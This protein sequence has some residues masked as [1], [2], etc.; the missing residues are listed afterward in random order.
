[1]NEGEFKTVLGTFKFDKKGDPSLPPYKF[2]EW[3]NG[4]YDQIN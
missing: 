2:Y 3:K 4:N 1:L